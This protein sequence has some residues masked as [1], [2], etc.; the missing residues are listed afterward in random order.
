MELQSII[1]FGPVV[2]YVACKMAS[3]KRSGNDYM[4]NMYKQNSKFIVLLH[5]F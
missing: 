2:G 4:L 1:T 5:H 3:S